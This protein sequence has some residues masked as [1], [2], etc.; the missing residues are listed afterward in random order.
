MTICQFVIGSSHHMGCDG[1]T[2]QKEM[3]T[4]ILGQAGGR[5]IRSLADSLWS[6]VLE[7]AEHLLGVVA[8]ALL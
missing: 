6:P 8:L 7:E 3:G 5:R 1:E 4:M 2:G